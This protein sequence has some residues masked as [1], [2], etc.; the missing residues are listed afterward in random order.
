MLRDDRGCTEHLRNS[1]CVCV[2]VCVCV[3]VCE[4]A[5]VCIIFVSAHAPKYMCTVH[6]DHYYVE[7]ISSFG[8]YATP[9]G[10]LRNVNYQ[11]DTAAHIPHTGAG[12]HTSH[13][14]NAPATQPR[15]HSTYKKVLIDPPLTYHHLT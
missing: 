5:H 13:P 12:L 15:L 7:P 2:C 6:T 4:C 1:V 11:V 14:Y 10:H 3:S 9:A 8:C